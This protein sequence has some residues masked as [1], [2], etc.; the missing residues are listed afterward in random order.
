MQSAIEILNKHLEN[1]PGAPVFGGKTYW[2]IIEAMHEFQKQSDWTNE[3]VDAAYL[4]GAL[5]TAENPLEDIQSEI[6]RLKALGVERPHEALKRIRKI[7][8]IKQHG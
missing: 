4:M 7:K 5:N 1:A 8:E 3:D 6:K 2:T